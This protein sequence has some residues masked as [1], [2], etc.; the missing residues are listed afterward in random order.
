MVIILGMSDPKWAQVDMKGR[1]GLESK[2]C[3]LKKMALK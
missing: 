1:N 3:K 2:S